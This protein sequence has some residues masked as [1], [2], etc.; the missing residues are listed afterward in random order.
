MAFQEA[1]NHQAT[2]EDFLPMFLNV[3]I[4]SRVEGSLRQHPDGRKPSSRLKSKAN[5]SNGK[6]RFRKENGETLKQGLWLLVFSELW[7]HRGHTARQTQK[8]REPVPARGPS[9]AAIPEPIPK[10]FAGGDAVFIFQTLPEAHRYQAFFQRTQI[11]GHFSVLQ[12]DRDR[13]VTLFQ[14]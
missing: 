11:R 7:N 1:Q 13:S 5:D 9:A 4:F 2:R 12:K 3:V 8:G 10:P 14:N 6:N